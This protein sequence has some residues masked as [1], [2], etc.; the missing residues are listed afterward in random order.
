MCAGG[1]CSQLFIQGQHILK[2]T[3]Q[4]LAIRSEKQQAPT[5]HYL[6]WQKMMWD[7]FSYRI[8]IQQYRSLKLAVR[9][10]GPSDI[11]MSALER[12]KQEEE[13]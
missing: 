9:E 8:E 6:Q 3:L 5:C 12:K 1:M 4:K 11:E 13:A 2:L 10:R 7:S